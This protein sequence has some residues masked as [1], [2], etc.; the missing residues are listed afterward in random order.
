MI[1]RSRYSTQVNRP[2]KCV[3]DCFG[4]QNRKLYEH[5]GTEPECQCSVQE[6]TE[7]EKNVPIGMQSS[8]ITDQTTVKKS[9][10]PKEKT[11]CILRKRSRE[12]GE[13]DSWK[14]DPLH[15]NPLD[16]LLDTLLKS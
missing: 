16:T 4:W 13:K 2:K 11:K 15:S 3:G 12:F 9:E 7:T 10:S 5:F 14:S 6:N 8:S 1:T